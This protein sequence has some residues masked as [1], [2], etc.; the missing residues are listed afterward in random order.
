MLTINV[1]GS[2]DSWYFRDLQRAAGKN[3]RIRVFDYSKIE[4][5]VGVSEAGGAMFPCDAAILRSMPPGSLEQIVFRMDALANLWA[6]GVY[7]LNS[8]RAM[9][10]AIDK[11]LSTSRLSAAGICTPATHVSQTWQTAMEGYHALG[12]DVVIKPLFGGEGRGIT[13]VTDSDLAERAFKMLEQLS[14]VIYQQTFVPHDGSDVRILLLGE[15]SW[16]MRRHNAGD[17]R[18]NVSRGA[19]VEPFSMSPDLLQL[20]RRAADVVDAEFAGVD[21]LEGNNG[22]RYVLEV[23]AVPG[24]KALSKVLNVDIASEVLHHIESRLAN[25]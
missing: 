24:W 10:V 18:T 23:N 6:K 7:V 21:I 14:A 15:K 1:F 4:C 13:R 16:G 3:T 22:K 11:Y 2:P 5:S 17:W 12:G 25:R 19:S 8:P 9:E 20:A